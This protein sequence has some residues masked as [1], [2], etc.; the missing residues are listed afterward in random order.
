MLLVVVLDLTNYVEFTLQY[1]NTNTIQYEY[2][3]Y[4]ILCSIVD[5]CRSLFRKRVWDV[6][7]SSVA[8]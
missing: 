4:Y 6:F 3:Q 5:M 2:E 8:F 7:I 1:Y